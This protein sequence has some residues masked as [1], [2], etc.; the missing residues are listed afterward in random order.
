MLLAVQ[1][2]AWLSF[3]SLGWC[4]VHALAIALVFY[5]G[6]RTGLK[7]RTPAGKAPPAGEH[8]P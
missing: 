6:V 1:L 7:L 2:P 8:L 3:L 5:L 4:I